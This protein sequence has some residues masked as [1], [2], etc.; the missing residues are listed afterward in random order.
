MSQWRKGH[1]ERDGRGTDTNTWRGE[2]WL[3]V[4]LRLLEKG[5]WVGTEERLLDKLKA[6]AVEGVYQ[7]GGF[8]GTLDELHRYVALAH[9]AFAEPDLD[10]LDYRELSG[11]LLEY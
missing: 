8:L 9:G 2:P 6:P 1:G 3:A 4:L 11:E 5:A 10:L 7:S